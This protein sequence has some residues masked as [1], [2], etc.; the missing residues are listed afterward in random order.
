MMK[1]ISII[2]TFAFAILLTIGCEQNKNVQFDAENGQTYAAFRGSS[3]NLPINID[4][5]V[6]SVTVMLDVTTAKP[7]DRTIAISVKDNSTAT[8]AMYSFNQSVTVPAGEYNTTFTI[9]GMTD[10]LMAGDSKKLVLEVSSVDNGVVSTSEFSVN[11]FLVCPIP[12]GAFTGS[13][14]IEQTS[15]YVDGPTLSTGTIVTVTATDNDSRTFQTEAY[16]NYCSGTFFAFNFDLVCGAIKVPNLNTT[17]SCG[18][19][20]DWFT[21]AT[22]PETY[23]VNDDSS[24]LLTFTDDTQNNCGSA[25]QTTY[26]FTKQ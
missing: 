4:T 15:P 5:G 14:L 2:L 16:P 11:L 12:D 10:V 18:N 17:C 25:V 22:T 19:A 8:T 23:N 1:K 3:V 21:G 13:Y 9:D 6:G 7:T 24:F 20:T 26:K